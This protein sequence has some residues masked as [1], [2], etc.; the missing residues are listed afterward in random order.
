[1]KS[2]E[3]K[4]NEVYKQWYGINYCRF[5]IET[6]KKVIASFMEIGFVHDKS[7]NYNNGYDYGAGVYLV[8]PDYDYEINV[9][10]WTDIDKGRRGYLSKKLKKQ[11]IEEDNTPIN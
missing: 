1:M 9:G 4:V 3:N 11:L 7:R 6:T 2:L 5:D 10:T 8:H